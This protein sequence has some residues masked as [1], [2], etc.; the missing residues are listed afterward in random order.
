MKLKLALVASA[1]AL[2]F[3]LAAHPASATPYAFTSSGTF[4]GGDT[5]SYG[6]TDPT[7]TDQSEIGWG[8][9]FFSPD[10]TLTAVSLSTSQTGNTPAT[11]DVIGELAWYNGNNIAD[12]DKSTVEAN[13]NL[14]LT[15]T[16]PGAGGSTTD[17]IGLVIQNTRGSCSGLGCSFG[18]YSKVDDTLVPFNT[19]TMLSVDG[20]ILSNFSFSIQGGSNGIYDLATNTWSNPEGKKSTLLIMANISDD[21]ANVPEPASLALLG[22]G[23]FGLGLIRR[24]FSASSKPRA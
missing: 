20:L 22:T 9:S 1:L 11:G 2:P 19:S 23:L 13:Y 4:S 14:T 18:I 16:K 8:G 5:T 21:P 24:R 7:N 10:S 17:T 12:I 15:F 3:A 6:Y